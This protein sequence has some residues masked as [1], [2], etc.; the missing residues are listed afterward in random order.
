MELRNRAVVLAGT[1]SLVGL[2]WGCGAGTSD[3]PVTDEKEN[4]EQVDQAQ[5]QGGE[6]DFKK[7][8]CPPGKVDDSKPGDCPEGHQ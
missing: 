6:D 8:R 5:H 7:K 4:T 2:F 1:F 3:P